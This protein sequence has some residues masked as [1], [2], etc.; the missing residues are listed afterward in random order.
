MIAFASVRCALL[1]GAALLLSVGCRV[2]PTSPDMENTSDG[3]ACPAEGKIEDAEDNNN[4]ILVQDGRAG[5]V[6][7]YVDP[8]GSTIDPA[9]G[10]VFTMSPGGA[11]GSQFAL[12][13][14]G[15]I[16]KTDTVYAALG[17]NFADPRGPYDL[18][19]YKGVSFY[20]KKGPGTTSKVRIK[21]PDKNTDPEGGVC[22]H[23]SNDFGMA[24]SLSEEWQKFIVPFSA[25]RQEAGWGNPRPRSLDTS[26]V[27]ALQF[28]VNDKGKK[29]DVMIDD[30]AFTGC[31]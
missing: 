8:A 23:C 28:Q 15:D 14:H 24:L 16:A 6:Y 5:Y 3:K 13:I 11:N 19:K 22:G 17:M 25:L 12:R 31:E 26:A 4:Q 10:A 20:A 1:G 2:N 30:I 27:Y 7:T 18:S 9:G 29:F 21:F